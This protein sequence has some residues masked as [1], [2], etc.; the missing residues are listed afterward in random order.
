[1]K[2][3]PSVSR[4]IR[5]ADEKGCRRY[6]VSPQLKSP[7]LKTPKS[8]DLLHCLVE[9]FSLVASC[10]CSLRIIGWRATAMDFSNGAPKSSG[11]R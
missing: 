7:P 11:C 9:A 6:D 10:L 4:Y 1:M 2:S 8:G 3:L 5:I